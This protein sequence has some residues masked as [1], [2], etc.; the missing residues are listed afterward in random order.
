MYLK[1]AITAVFAALA[2][3][4]LA[5]AQT[6]VDSIVDDANSFTSVVSCN[7]DELVIQVSK[8]NP[9]SQ[10][11]ILR[12]T[13]IANYLDVV[14]FDRK[15]FAPVRD[16][17]VSTGIGES[18]RSGAEWKGFSSALNIYRFPALIPIPET[19]SA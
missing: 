17:F 6:P 9:A 4:V 5:S 13:T 2:T 16:I 11:A 15:K 1:S 7:D 18:T 3:P 12:N 19:R 8:E 10:R 14:S